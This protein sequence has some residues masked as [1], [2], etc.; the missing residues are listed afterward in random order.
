MDGIYR[1]GFGNLQV[2][3]R[4]NVDESERTFYDLS[5]DEDNNITL[6]VNLV[7]YECTEI[8]PHWGIEL[9]FSKHT[10]PATSGEVVIFLDEQMVDLSRPVRL[11]VNGRERFNGPVELCWEA[12][13]AS[14][15]EFGDPT[16]LF[17]ASLRVKID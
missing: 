8:D 9:K 1:T 3:E 17:P 6:N 2:I 7:A 11:T 10:R 12:L 5:I 16:R 14:C 15:R 13:R 4:S